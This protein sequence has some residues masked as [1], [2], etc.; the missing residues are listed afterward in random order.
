MAGKIS[1]RSVPTADNNRNVHRHPFIYSIRGGKDDSKNVSEVEE[2]EEVEESKPTSP[3]L[4]STSALYRLN[5]DAMADAQTRNQDDDEGPVRVD[6][7]NEEEGNAK[8]KKKNEKQQPKQKHILENQAQNRR[9][10]ALTATQTPDTTTPNPQQQQRGS[11]NIFRWLAP[12]PAGAA[13]GVS[14]DNRRL[15][16]NSDDQVAK[17]KNEEEE[18]SND[19]HD[20]SAKAKAEADLAQLWWVNVWTQQLPDRRPQEEVDEQNRLTTDT[21]TEQESKKNI[22]ENETRKK[23]HKKKKTAFQDAENFSKP[24]QTKPGPALTKDEITTLEGTGV[25]Q[26]YESVKNVTSLLAQATETQ[27]PTKDYVSSGY[28]SS[29]NRTRKKSCYCIFT[30]LFAAISSPILFVG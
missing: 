26:N 7:G 9:G 28:V 3:N 27:Q 19:D 11:G 4:W 13:E 15:D 16:K 5:E 2:G 8:N 22:Q 20:S 24:D 10:G 6:D 25:Q 12:P 23:K 21:E 1:A 29:T 14:S 30:F 17:A 18:P